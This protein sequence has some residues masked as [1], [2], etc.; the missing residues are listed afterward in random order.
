MGRKR[1]TKSGVSAEFGQLYNL[2]TRN[3]GTHFAFA[4]HH[5]LYW[6]GLS[7]KAQA[8]TY[9]LYPKMLPEKAGPSSQ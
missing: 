7:L 1:H 2:D 9:A 4:L 3:N 6:K 5:E 8:T